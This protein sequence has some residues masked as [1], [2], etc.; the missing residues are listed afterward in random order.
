MSRRSEYPMLLNPERGGLNE[1]LHFGYVD[2]PAEIRPEDRPFLDTLTANSLALQKEIR[3]PI[4]LETR[5]VCISTSYGDVPAR[6]YLPE[7]KGPFPL[8]M[9]Y[10]GGGFAIRDIECFDW[11]SRRYAQGAGAVVITIE[12]SLA[13]EHRFPTQAEQAYE[14]LLWARKHAGEFCADASRDAVTGDSAGG[15]LSTVVSMM[16]RDR[17]ERVPKRQ[18]LAYPVVDAR[19]EIVRESDELYGT[20]YNLDYKHLLSYNKAYAASEEVQNPYVSPLLAESLAE[21]PPCRMVS[22]QCDVLLDSGLEYAKR[23]KDAGVE[24]EVHIFKGVPHDFLFYGFPES[25]EAYDLICQWIR[26]I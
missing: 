1:G 13:P 17:G 8:L 2:V 26:E 18:I 21:M 24:T 22:A 16:C 9:H 5:D 3:K 10:H 4:P 20:G 19:P 11:L 12:Y 15:N 23:L 6:I 25:Y 14:A 7:G